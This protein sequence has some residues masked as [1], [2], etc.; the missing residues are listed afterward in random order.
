MPWSVKS[1]GCPSPPAP[2][3]GSPSCV[4]SAN[5]IPPTRNRSAAMVWIVRIEA[6]LAHF[7]CPG[8]P[9]VSD[10][11]FS[12]LEPQVFPRQQQEDAEPFL[13]LHKPCAGTGQPREQPCEHPQRHHG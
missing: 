4:G 5:A 13:Y 1:T 8:Y 9:D 3:N 6:L 7:R 12:R 11:P 2:W 10:Q